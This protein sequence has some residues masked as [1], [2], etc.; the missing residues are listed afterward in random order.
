[1]VVK[2]LNKNF[3]SKIF[4]AF[5]FL[6]VFRVGV[7][8]PSPFVN[9]QYFLSK[10]STFTDGLFI[11]TISTIS[12]SVFGSFSILSLGV[13]PYILSSIMTQIASYIYQDG[14]SN[15][16]KDAAFYAKISRV[17][18]L[19]FALIQSIIL[20]FTMKNACEVF[21]C[22]VMSKQMIYFISLISV[23]AG[24]MISVWIGEAITEYCVGNGISM[25]IFTNI[26]FDFVSA[27]IKVFSASDGRLSNLLLA[28]S[29]IFG[30]ICVIVLFE[31]SSR[32]VEVQYSSSSKKHNDN[33]L[34]FIPM[35]LNFAG[36]MPMIFTATII[37]FLMSSINLALGMFGGL[38]DNFIL[39]ALRSKVFY[40]CIYFIFILVFAL[41]YNN[42]SFN[43]EKVS[44]SLRKTSGVVLNVKPGLMTTQY[45][46]NLLRKLTTIGVCYL[47]FVSV[48]VDYFKVILNIDSFIGGT[49][50]LIITVI[51][52]E[53]IN[54]YQVEMLNAKYSEYV[55]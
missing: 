3:I 8:L 14:K 32:L 12:S 47:F 10:L 38:F 6:F 11:G 24:S 23:V 30:V 35:K 2:M 22:S 44:D 31:K 16:S 49:S 18:T 48:F 13:M 42:V 25:I 46:S 41:I 37:S 52:L 15:N 53:L 1:M 28:L 26:G 43:V 40:Y 54:K 39:F 55:L 21:Y 51:A 36:V 50:Y 17:F 45:F 33:L 20:L 7:H 19:V 29:L 9:S 5:L 27:L 4:L 34:S